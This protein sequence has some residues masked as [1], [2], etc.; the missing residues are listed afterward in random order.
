VTDWPDEMTRTESVLRKEYL[1]AIKSGN[2]GDY[3]ALLE[4]QRRFTPAR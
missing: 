1:D 4:L 2:G 3:A